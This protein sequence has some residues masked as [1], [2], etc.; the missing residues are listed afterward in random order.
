MTFWETNYLRKIQ[1]TVIALGKSKLMPILG[2]TDYLHKQS[3]S[4][5]GKVQCCVGKT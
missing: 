4:C 1:T 2:G 3:V 5:L